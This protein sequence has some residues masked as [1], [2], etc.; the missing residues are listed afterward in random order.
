MSDPRVTLFMQDFAGGGAER[1]MVSLANGLAE[2]GLSV[3]LVV[4]RLEGPN[5]AAVAPSV[6]VVDLG[7]PAVMKSLGAF[8]SYCKEAKPVAVLSALQQPNTIACWARKKT[9]IR[10]VVA[11]HTNLSSDVANAQSLRLKL[12]PW[13]VRAFFRGADAI[14]AVSK[15][16]A[17]DFSKLGWIPRD[18]VN[19]I[20]N[21]VIFPNLSERAAECPEHPW[22]L[23]SIPVIVGIGRLTAQKDFDNLIRAFRVVRD[24]VNARLLILGEGEDRQKLEALTKEL[25]LSDSVAL[26]GFVKNPY[27]ILSNSSVFSLSSRWEGLPTVLIEALACDVP[28]VATNCPSGPEEILEGGKYGALVPMKDAS[29]LAHAILATLEKPKPAG[30][31]SWQPYV[32]RTV[33]EQYRDL[34][35]NRARVKPSDRAQNPI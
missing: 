15:G 9:G 13:F 3:D 5:L 35:L 2:L 24:S 30:P 29:A 16:V 32:A 33:C 12:M 11:I 14:V 4:C 25:E 19:V 34:L 8:V 1:V 7:C 21:P 10:T 23:E 17:D 20:V 27:A 22:L 18:R 6:N 31:E 28:V 26:P